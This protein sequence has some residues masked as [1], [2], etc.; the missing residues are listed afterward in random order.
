MINTDFGINNEKNQENKSEMYEKTQ[1]EKEGM[2][3]RWT[4][5]R[6]QNF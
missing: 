1:K 4:E 5:A 3:N 6:N 2:R